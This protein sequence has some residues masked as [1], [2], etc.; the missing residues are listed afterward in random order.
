MA[1]LC[2]GI[3]NTISVQQKKRKHISSNQ[4]CQILTKQVRNVIGAKSRHHLEIKNFGPLW[5]WSQDAA[6]THTG[7]VTQILHIVIGLF[8]KPIFPLFP[9]VV[10]KSGCVIAVT[11]RTVDPPRLGQM[12][13]TCLQLNSCRCPRNTVYFRNT[14]LSV[15]FAPRTPESKRWSHGFKREGGSEGWNLE[16]I[17]TRRVEMKAAESLIIVMIQRGLLETWEQVEWV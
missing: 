6:S 17:E 12:V 1:L 4:A 3:R 13:R 15:A 5:D 10:V 16:G 14:H 9:R 11:L 8:Q 2:L 7:S